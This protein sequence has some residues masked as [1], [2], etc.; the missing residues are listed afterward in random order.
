[1]WRYVRKTYNLRG[2][3]GKQEGRETVG[4]GNRRRGKQ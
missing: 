2:G 4:E 3:G 1:M